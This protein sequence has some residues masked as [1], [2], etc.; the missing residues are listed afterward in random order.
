MSD[1]NPSIVTVMILVLFG[2][3]FATSVVI[4]DTWQQINLSPSEQ[5]EALVPQ[6]KVLSE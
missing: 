5:Q 4:K 1:S 6:T 3:F 2:A